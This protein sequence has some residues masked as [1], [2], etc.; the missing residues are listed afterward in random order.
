MG[1]C[2]TMLP[3]CRE[4]Q[5]K[6]LYF[7]RLV[8]NFS[9][10]M[11]YDNSTNNTET[12]K[13]MKEA[14]AWAFSAMPEAIQVALQE[15]QQREKEQ[16]QQ[17]AVPNYGFGNYG[18]P[19]QNQFGNYGGGQQGNWFNSQ[20]SGG[21]TQQMPS[22]FGKWWNTQRR[23][24]AKR[25]GVDA[26]GRPVEMPTELLAHQAE[27]RFL[28]G[29]PYRL[30]HD[31]LRKMIKQGMLP[32]DDGNSKKLGDLN[33][34]GFYLEDEDE[35]IFAEDE[36]ISAEPSPATAAG[37]ATPAMA[38]CAVVATALATVNGYGAPLQAKDPEQCEAG[39]E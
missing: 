1:M 19:N 5:F 8:F 2:D 35:P 3:G 16:K 29:L 18:Q 11:Y 27:I 39:L 9:R 23:L 15:L 37:W 34:I 13:L 21:T 17:T 7:P 32:V 14:M 4:A 38:A 22:A 24:T 36:P 10:P 20:Q 26:D 30:T 33:I 28:H 25:M 31:V 12:T 6:S